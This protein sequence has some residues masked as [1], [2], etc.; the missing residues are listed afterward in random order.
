VRAAEVIAAFT[1]LP[2]AFFFSSAA[3]NGERQSRA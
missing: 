2:D 3:L 1:A